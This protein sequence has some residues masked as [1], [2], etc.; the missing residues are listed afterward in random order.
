V[1]S[2]T[3][4]VARRSDLSTFLVHFGR[5]GG[6]ATAQQNLYR[7]LSTGE[8]EARNP[9][10]MAQSRI[11]R[12]GLPADH[13][14]TVS[15]KVV[16]FTETPLEFSHLLFAGIEDRRFQFEPYGIAV[17]KKVGRRRGA[18][19]VWY[20]DMTIGHDWL[21]KSLDSM[22]DAAWP[23]FAGTH[24]A[25]LTPFMEQMGSWYGKRKEFW[26][27]REW[28]HVGDFPLP[29]HFIGLCPANEIK[30]FESYATAQGRPVRFIDP[31]WGL[32][33]IIGKLAGF[34]ADEIGPF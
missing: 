15:Q 13:P 30:V 18:N 27:E 7:I 21:T 31:N 25:K 11:E 28:R 10:G 29:D 6:G 20:L 14:V 24:L 4:I 26:W 5:D 17:S 32:E 2:I 12:S 9:Y 34:D 16:C 33:Q 22:I 8:L 3:E 23:D 19:P 1:H